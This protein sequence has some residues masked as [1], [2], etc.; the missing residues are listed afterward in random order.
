VY[1]IR[2]LLRVWLTCGLLFLP[3][4]LTGAQTPSI[5]EVHIL[6][7][8]TYRADITARSKKPGTTGFF[9]TVKNA[10]LISSTTSV[11]GL[12]GVRFGVR[13]VVISDTSGVKLPL[14][15]VI[16]FPPGGL[17]N[18]ITGELFLHSEHD[19]L[20]ATGAKSYWEYLF[21]NEWEIAEGI[22]QFEFWDGSNK[23]SEQRFCVY[24]PSRQHYSLGLQDICHPAFLS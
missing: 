11:P 23:L 2:R 4:V 19:M 16:R 1:H 22:W 8:G 15:L 3:A 12:V 21:E 5:R 7:R 18:P 9:N 13:Y 10:Q 14:R 6:E 20:V 24:D 17:R